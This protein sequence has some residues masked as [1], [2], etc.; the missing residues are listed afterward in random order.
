VKNQF[1][2]DSKDNQ[3][4]K[5]MFEL[6]DPD[7]LKDVAKVLTFGANKYGLFNWQNA[8]QKELHHLTGAIYRHLN[9]YQTGEI[10]DKESKLQHMAHIS[11]NAMFLHWFFNNKVWRS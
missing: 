4:S 8:K 2:K 11:V 5:P 1:K 3:F 7:F 10:F 9:E 6:I